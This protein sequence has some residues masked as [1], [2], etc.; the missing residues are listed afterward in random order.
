MGM[1]H[2]GAWDTNLQLFPPSFIEH[3]FLQMGWLKPEVS[4]ASHPL[5][6]HYVDGTKAVYPNC[7]APVHL[8]SGSKTLPA[9]GTSNAWKTE[10]MLTACAPPYS[11]ACVHPTSTLVSKRVNYLTPNTQYEGE[12]RSVGH[13]RKKKRMVKR[14]LNKEKTEGGERLKDWMRLAVCDS[15]SKWIFSWPK[16]HHH[17]GR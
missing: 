12:K 2:L 17:H 1:C 3:V 15:G 7:S 8:F 14:K 4:S 13:R 5:P 10:V 9:S 16:N 11:P 6:M